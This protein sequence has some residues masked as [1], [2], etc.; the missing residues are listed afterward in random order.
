MG[1]NRTEGRPADRA[2]QQLTWCPAHWCPDCCS[3]RLLPGAEHGSIRDR[4]EDDPVEQRR[5][6]R[7]QHEREHEPDGE[8]R[9]SAHRQPVDDRAQVAS[10]SRSLEIEYVGVN[11]TAP[12][13]VIYRYRLEGFDQSW[14]EAGAR[15]A[16]HRIRKR[17]REIFE[18]ATQREAFGVR[19]ACSRFFGWEVHGQSFY[20]PEHSVQPD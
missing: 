17:F 18:A 4:A 13:K 1:R 12:E 14:Q 5:D 11:L 16:V 15:T 7:D 8:G 9:I 3:A 20:A 10:G 19:G 2:G 6:R